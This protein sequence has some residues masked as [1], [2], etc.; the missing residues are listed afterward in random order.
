MVRTSSKAGSNQATMVAAS[1]ITP[2]V[3]RFTTSDGSPRPGPLPA[4]LRKRENASSGQNQRAAGGASQQSGQ[5][6][7]CMH[8]TPSHPS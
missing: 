1:R 5:I 8:H 3:T 6:S 7:S 4:Q 2:A